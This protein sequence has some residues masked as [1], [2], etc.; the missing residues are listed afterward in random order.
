MNRYVCVWLWL[1]HRNIT[2]LKIIFKIYRNQ[3][4]SHTQCTTHA[5]I[6]NRIEANSDSSNDANDDD[7]GTHREPNEKKKSRTLNI[8][9]THM[10]WFMKYSI[11]YYRIFTLVIVLFY[12]RESRL[13]FEPGFG[14]ARGHTDTRYHK[15]KN[16]REG[17]F[18]LFTVA[19]SL[20]KYTPPIYLDKI[21]WWPLAHTHT[22]FFWGWRIF[23]ICIT[24]GVVYFFAIDTIECLSC[25]NYYAQ[26]YIIPLWLM[27][28]K[29]IKNYMYRILCAFFRFIFRNANRMCIL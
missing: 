18:N 4:F 15:T 7:N 8:F 3:W 5:Y 17:S 21:C 10:V 12:G 19:L 29:H 14:R 23:F 27:A 26:L 9:I 16:R 25:M 2:S 1:G 11:L 28:F 6:K 24:R 13:G 20:N 22:H